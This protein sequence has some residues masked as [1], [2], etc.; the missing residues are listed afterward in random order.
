MTGFIT[1]RG[2]RE[3]GRRVDPELM[4]RVVESTGRIVREA[5]QSFPGAQESVSLLISLVD[6]YREG[7]YGSIPYWAVGTMVVALMSI[8]NPS[9]LVPDILPALSPGDRETLLGLCLEMVGDELVLYRQWC[10][11]KT[12]DGGSR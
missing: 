10:R 9:C 8:I 1:E 4:K 5:E 6:D 3:A 7:R 12:N 11:T 2:M